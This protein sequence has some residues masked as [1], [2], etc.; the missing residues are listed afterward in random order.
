M[1]IDTSSGFA[2]LDQAAVTAVRQWRFAPARHGD[3]PVA[4]WARVPIRFRLDEAG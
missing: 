1:E 2:R 4:A 3:V